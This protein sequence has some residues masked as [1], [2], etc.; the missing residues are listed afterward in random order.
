MLPYLMKTLVQ[1]KI[2]IP[3]AMKNSCLHTLLS[4]LC[5]IVSAHPSTAISC[6]AARKLRQKKQ[7]VRIA[8]FGACALD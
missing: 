1:M 3:D 4:Y 5:S 6:V 8:M 2:I 7:N